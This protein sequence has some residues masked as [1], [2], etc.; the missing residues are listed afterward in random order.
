MKIKDK[1]QYK[2][3]NKKLAFPSG[4][5]LQLFIFLS[6]YGCPTIN[7]ILCEGFFPKNID[8]MMII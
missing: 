6:H 3:R 5:Y 8:R 2:T 1:R 4:I 7:I